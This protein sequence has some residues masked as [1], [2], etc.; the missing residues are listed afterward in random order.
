MTNMRYSDLVFYLID[1]AFIQLAH[2]GVIGSMF[3]G[4]QRFRSKLP[5]LSVNSAEP[6]SFPVAEKSFASVYVL[7]RQCG[8]ASHFVLL[9]YSVRLYCMR[10]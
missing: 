2:G 5:R 4:S 7:N 9:I 10:H 1:L 8:E 6:L 3:G